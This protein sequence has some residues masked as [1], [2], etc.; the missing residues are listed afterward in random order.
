MSEANWKLISSNTE[1]F[2]FESFARFKS[3][4]EEFLK[5]KYFFSKNNP[6]I[7]RAIFENVLFIDKDRTVF[8]R[9]TLCYDDAEKSHSEGKIGFFKCH[10]DFEIFEVFLQLLLDKLK[11]KGFKKILAPMNFSSWFEYRYL[12]KEKPGYLEGKKLFFEPSNEAFYPLFFQRFGFTEHKKY[13]SFLTGKDYFEK[14]RNRG[15]KWFELSKKKNY[16]IRNFDISRMQSELKAVYDIFYITFADYPGLTELSFEEFLYYIRPLQSAIKP[17]LIK[18]ICDPSGRAVGV[19]AG[20]LSI[21]G[22]K[23]A[24]LIFTAC[25]SKKEIFCSSALY[26]AY[27]QEVIDQGFEDGILS[28]AADTASTLVLLKDAEIIREFALFEYDLKE[29]I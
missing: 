13:Y 11:I 24:S 6:F 16:V 1:E 7:K 25:I 27:A 28:L 29:S 3:S 21:P 9:A 18:F 8:G 10:E 19:F 23:I 22:E 2:D 20:F 4:E 12:V 15:K 17:E 26:H 5:I 14:M